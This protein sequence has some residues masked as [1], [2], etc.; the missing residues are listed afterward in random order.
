MKKI[1]PFA[2]EQDT[3]IGDELWNQE[4]TTRKVPHPTPG[5]RRFWNTTRRTAELPQTE[6]VPFCSSVSQ[7]HPCR[8]CGFTSALEAL[9]NYTLHSLHLFLFCP[10]WKN[11]PK[12][13]TK[14]RMEVERKRSVTAD[15]LC[16]EADESTGGGLIPN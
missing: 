12:R 16:W 10:S 8:G 7:H 6:S 9:V 1:F 5:N 4:S 11:K 14:W 13:N 2:P 3:E 15:F